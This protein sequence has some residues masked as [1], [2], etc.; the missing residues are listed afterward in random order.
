MWQL[1][2]AYLNCPVVFL[3]HHA[4]TEPGICGQCNARWLKLEAVVIDLHKVGGRAVV[5]FDHPNK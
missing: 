5:N 1:E 3:L 4:F 2:E